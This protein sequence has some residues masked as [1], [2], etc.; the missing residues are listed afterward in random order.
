MSEPNPTRT[1]VLEAVIARGDRHVGRV[2]QAA[3]E[4]AARLDA[5]NEH[6]DWDKWTAAFR[7]AGVDPAIYAHRELPTDARLPWSHVACPRREP[8]LL[9]EYRRMKQALAEPAAP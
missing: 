8:V 2:I 6:W 7:Q 9:R 5:W 4:G 1:S 3:W